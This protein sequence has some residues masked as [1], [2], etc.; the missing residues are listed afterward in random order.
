MSK[1]IIGYL[2]GF[3]VFASIIPYAIRVYQRKI[4]ANIITWAIWSVLGGAILLNYR[5]VGAEDNKWPAVFGCINP[6]LIT[7][8]AILRGKIAPITKF[9]ISCFIIGI[10][11]IILWWNLRLD[12]ETVQYALY[13][14]IIG[15]LC[16]GV[17]TWNYVK[18]N[19]AEDRPL[20]WLLYM[21]GYGIAVFAITEHTFSNYILP[22]YMAV[23][24][25]I[26]T[27]PLIRYRIQ[28]KIPIKEWW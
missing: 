8:L 22:I 12:K 14:G 4:T 15:D 16:A 20:M 25:G 7:L 23:M 1:E 28:A 10:L 2:S 26:I 18:K 6:V 19:P 3:L 9:D 24:S 21:L 27:I 5:A 11:S 13:V 17:P